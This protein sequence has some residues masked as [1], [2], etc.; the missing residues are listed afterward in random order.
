MSHRP[1]HISCPLINFHSLCCRPAHCG[2][3]RP[4]LRLGRWLG[5]GA[6]SMW[7]DSRRSD[8]RGATRGGL[9]RRAGRPPAAACCRAPAAVHV[10]PHK[11]LVPE[12]RLCIMS[13]SWWS[14][15]PLISV[16]AALIRCHLPRPARATTRRW[17]E[18]CAICG[19][20]DGAVM[21]C[22]QPGGCS[23]TFHVLC[24]RNI[25]LHLGGWP[26]LAAGS[27][28]CRTGCC[29]V[30]RFGA[31]GAM[32]LLSPSVPPE[33]STGQCLVAGC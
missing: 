12:P 26:L 16:C 14:R 4:S 11:G 2:C 32:A 18:R 5:W 21:A 6:K 29:W 9:W 30:R 28:A 17:N 20:V 31:L 19:L 10:Q 1:R 15:C 23:N 25:G 33:V 24:A 8:R 3:L 7:G 27:L 22:Q 13:P